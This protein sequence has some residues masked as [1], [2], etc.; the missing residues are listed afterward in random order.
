MK[1][2]KLNYKYNDFKTLSEETMKYHYEVLYKGYVDNYNRELGSLEVAR[3][4]N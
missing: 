4:N 3:N 1:I 2:I